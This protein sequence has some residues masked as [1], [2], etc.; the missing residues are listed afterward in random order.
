MSCNSFFHLTF[1]DGLRNPATMYVGAA[2]WSLP[3]P[4]WLEGGG[5]LSLCLLKVPFR[6]RSLGLRRTLGGKVSFPGPRKAALD[7]V[8]GLR[9]RNR[10]FLVTCA[11]ITMSH[12]Q[13]PVHMYPCQYIRISISADVHSARASHVPVCGL[14]IWPFHPPKYT[15]GHWV[16][17]SPG[18]WYAF[19][20]L[21]FPGDTLWPTYR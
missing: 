21:V 16:E 4:R 19:L 10:A 3:N 15:A 7:G 14:T 5:F 8:E 1:G 17:P 20:S 6:G 11:S 9:P 12:L 2:G 13:S 18:K